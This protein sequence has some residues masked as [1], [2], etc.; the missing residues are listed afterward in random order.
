[1][2][3]KRILLSIDERLLARIDDART[4]RGATRSAYLAELA[5]QDLGAGPGTDARVRTAMARLDEH[6]DDA[7]A[8]DPAQI[9]RAIRS[10][11]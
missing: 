1:M 2:P 5:R 10:R 4:R 9:L 8:F 11:E 7:P 6:F 3:A